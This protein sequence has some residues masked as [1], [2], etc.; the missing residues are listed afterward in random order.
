MN[1]QRLF[2]ALLA[3]TLLAPT[4]GRAQGIDF[5]FR[6]VDVFSGVVFP[7]RADRGASFGAALW[8]GTA[9][10]PRLRWGLAL[11]Y[12]SA[13]RLDAAV[14]VRSILFSLDFL[15]PLSEGGRLVPYLGATGSLHSVD[16]TVEEGSLSPAELL[17]A[18]GVA[19][20]VAGYKLGG[21]GFAG[22][23]LHLTETGSVGVL[24]EYR[25]VGAPDVT[26]QEA[27]GGIRFSVGRR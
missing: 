18:E 23:V 8:L 12:A 3:L 10:H 9:F 24:L 2:P 25:L 27:R 26:H 11:D 19:D 22:L 16:T 4:E 1:G 7:T 13:D 6:G 21:G 20:D 17:A 15:F 14:T 5:S